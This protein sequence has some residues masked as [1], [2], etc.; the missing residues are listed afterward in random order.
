MTDSDLSS[1]IAALSPAKRA[2]L[3]QRL[4]QGSEV[5]TRNRISKRSPQQN[6]LLSFAQERLWFLSLLE[7][8]ARAY[9]LGRAYQ[10]SGP[11]D[12]RAL[13]KS[14]EEILRRH[15]A[16]RTTFA[17]AEGN[18]V[19]VI[20]P[21]SAFKLPI[22]DL[23]EFPREQRFAEATRRAEREFLFRFDLQTGP[24]MRATLLRLDERE[25][26]LTLT[27]HHI[28]F[29]GWSG[30]FFRRELS[31]FYDA[32]SE[33]REP[34]W[35][36]LPIQYADY[37]IWQRS[38]MRGEQLESLLGYWR[39]QLAGAGSLELPAD[40]ARPPRPTYSGGRCSFVLGPS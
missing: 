33:G 24:L 25:H 20:V 1:R 15:E 19:Q 8:E 34:G 7:P 5:S 4:Q 12:V 31:D 18:P 26:L 13:E 39:G 21:H 27:F 38:W 32:F 35:A 29:D 37:A 30:D 3:M 22:I 36:D 10:L 9:N 28:V 23:T 40:R 16:L 2:T 14:L 11:L 6:A 17:S